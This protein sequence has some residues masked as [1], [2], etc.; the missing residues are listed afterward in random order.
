MNCDRERAPSPASE[1]WPASTVTIARRPDS[2]V[3]EGRESVDLD[4][5]RPRHGRH[6]GRLTPVAPKDDEAVDVDID[7]VR[8]DDDDITERRDRGDHWLRVVNQSLG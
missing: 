7:A 3:S 1:P 4:P 5:R 6:S 2:D 8:D